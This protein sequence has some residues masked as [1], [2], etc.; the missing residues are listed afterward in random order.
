MSGNRRVPAV[1][2]AGVWLL[3][4]R[5]GAVYW[6]ETQSLIVADLHFE[7][8]S[9]FARGGTFLPPY[10][11][12][13][14]LK[15]L[16]EAAKRF[17]AARIVALGD[18]FHDRQ[19]GERV[20]DE[21]RAAFSAL[22]ARHEF[23]WVRGNHDPEL[24]GW[25]EGL[26]TEELADAPFLFRHEPQPAPA[27]GE[28]AGH[29]HPVALVRIKGRRFRRRAFISDGTRLVLP[30]F[31]ALTGGLDV[32]DPAFQPVF[33]GPFHAYM[34]GQQTIV[35]VKSADLSAEMA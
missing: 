34:I 7:K 23:V 16:A 33:P 29:L 10:D 28:L 21:E 31:G 35:P 19:A 27:M 25:V 32:L 22:A 30:A 14:T 13:K 17:G 1:Q 3:L 20:V 4:D 12:L 15:K 18:S 9:S 8:A 6:P 11:T 26:V 24:P 5:S 2:V